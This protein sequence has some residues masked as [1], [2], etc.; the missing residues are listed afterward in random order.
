MLNQS[1]IRT[2][3]F[4]YAISTPKTSNL[5]LSSTQHSAIFKATPASKFGSSLN[6]TGQFC[7][8]ARSTWSSR[9]KTLPRMNLKSLLCASPLKLRGLT[10]SFLLSLIFYAV[11]RSTLLL[12]LHHKLILAPFST[13]TLPRQ[14]LSWKI[15]LCFLSNSALCAFQKKSASQQ[16]QEPDRFCLEKSIL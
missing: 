10:R 7:R 4:T 3:I 16:M 13:K 14:L 2:E 15:T 9:T 11:S 8:R 1:F 6:L 5:I 12:S